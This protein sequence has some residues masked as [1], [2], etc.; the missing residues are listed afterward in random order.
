[1]H[2]N[3][4]ALAESLRVPLHTAERLLADLAHTEPHGTAQ[5]PARLNGNTAAVEALA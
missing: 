5:V 2:I 4:E 1:M 3:R